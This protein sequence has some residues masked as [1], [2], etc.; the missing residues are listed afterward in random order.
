MVVIYRY[1]MKI[2]A[3]TL[4]SVFIT[5]CA[6]KQSPGV[7]EVALPPPVVSDDSL[8]VSLEEQQKL[9]VHL[10][11]VLSDKEAEINQLKEN[12]K[13]QVIE[14]QE[15]TSEVVL[16]ETKL[17]R[18]ATEA[19]VASLLA[20]VEILMNELETT[21][22]PNYQLSLQHLS[23]QLIDIA[24]SSFEQA[25]Y[26]VAADQVEQ[27]KQFINMLMDNHKKPETHAIS[28]AS[29]K[30]AIPLII[31][32]ESQL[33][34]QPTNSGNMVSMLKKSTPVVARG[35]KGTWLQVQT[36]VG[37]SGWIMADLV[38]VP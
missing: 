27:A 37:D 30:V 19:D 24:S 2:I 16:A 17:R 32:A 35:Y 6:M 13:S 31:K 38:E 28:E 14:L 5:G 18:F 10:L 34:Q 7:V 20:E 29:F 1:L 8:S 25:E 23:Q 22:G 12:E 33:R 21:F 36:A 4:L 11:H 26:S 3:M 9:I 15:T